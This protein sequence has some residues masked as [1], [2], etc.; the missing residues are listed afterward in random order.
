MTGETHMVSQGAHVWFGD[1]TIANPIGIG[2][3]L[4]NTLGSDQ[5]FISIYYR[6]SLRLFSNSATERVRIDLNGNVGIAM[7]DPSVKLDVTGDI[8]Y[9]GTITDVS[10]ERLKENIAPLTSNLDKLAVL[11]PVSFN[12]IGDSRTQLGFIA[13][14]VQQ[15]FP[16]TVSVIDPENGYLGLDYTQLIAPAIGAI[17]DIVS[18]IDLG[19]A[20]TT[21]ASMY[22][23]GQGNVGIGTTTPAYKLQVVGDV[24]A[25]SFVNISTRDSKKDISYLSDTENET[26]LEKLKNLFVARYHYEAEDSSAP[27]RTGLIAEESP[28]EILAAN[29]KG[30][31]L[32]KFVSFLA[33]AMKALA[34]KVDAVVAKVASFADVFT[35]QKLCVGNTC[36]TE[37]QLQALLSGV[38]TASAPSGTATVTATISDTTATTTT[39]DTTTS[40]TTTSTTT[41]TTTND[42]TASTT[43]SI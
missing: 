29:G 26:A 2:E 7:T 13:Q 33:S 24:A 34:A 25:Q 19:N 18:V 27:L 36:V 15:V 28:A 43:T 31:D 23:D 20:T 41:T 1:S 10:D 6:S 5:D 9:T 22:I 21:F 40:T 4:V 17:N 14:N 12:M 11:N 16:G 38:G 8:E 39:T 42:T 37:T 32:Y 3:G 30:V 35:T